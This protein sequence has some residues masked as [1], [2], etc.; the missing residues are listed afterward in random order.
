MSDKEF[1][2]LYDQTVQ[3]NIIAGNS[4]D[5]DRAREL[6]K[7]E[8]EEWYKSKD[9]YELAD[10][11]FTAIWL[12]YLVK[13]KEYHSSLIEAK[14]LANELNAW[15]YFKAVIESNY[16]KFMPISEYDAL[17]AAQ[18]C[19]KVAEQ[20]PERYK[21]VRF[22]RVDKYFVVIGNEYDSEGQLVVEGKVLKPSSYI[23]ADEIM[24]MPWG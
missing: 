1:N 5:I 8:W 12:H 3:W 7:A 9:L 24:G 4:R 21:Q 10:V 22:R 18:E 16:S 17:Q 6:C 23:P 15:H 13:G 14:N 20:Y 11:L 2:D 19:D